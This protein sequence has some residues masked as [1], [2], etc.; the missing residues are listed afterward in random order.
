MRNSFLLPAILCFSVMTTS[1][2][3]AQENE[4]IEFVGRI[5]NN[6]SGTPDIKVVD[7]LAYVATGNT[8]LQIV[9]VS[10]P[11][12][13][14]IVGYNELNGAWRVEIV[15]DNAYVV[16]YQQ[17]SI[18]SISDPEN[19]ELVGS[20]GLTEGG[21]DLVIE[22]DY[23]YL[24]C[25]SSGLQIVDISDPSN[26]EM[27][28]YEGPDGQWARDVVVS[29]D[30]AYLACGA[31]CGDF[32]EGEGGLWIVDV[33]NIENPSDILFIEMMDCFSVALIEGYLFVDNY[34]TLLVFSIDDPEDPQEIGSLVVP[35]SIWGF[36][37]CNEYVF[38]NTF[39]DEVVHIA[40]V[41][42]PTNPELVGSINIP[43][44]ENRISVVNELAFIVSTHIFD[45]D[46]KMRI[47]DLRDIEQPELVNH[48]ERNGYVNDVFVSDEMLYV[49]NGDKGFKTVSIEAPEQPVETGFLDTKSYYKFIAVSEDYTYTLYREDIRNG[50]DSLSIISIEDPEHPQEVRSM[51]WDYPNGRLEFAG[52]Y[53]Y[54]PDYD[55]GIIIIS[56]SD[57]EN[58]ADT[59]HN[60]YTPLVLNL[61][62]SGDYLYAITQ[63]NG[64]YLISLTNPEFPIVIGY[65]DSL[66]TGS[67][68]KS[69]KTNGDFAF[70][71]SR[72]EYL[73]IFD[74]SEPENPEEISNIFIDYAKAIQ[75]SGHYV[76]LAQHSNG[77]SVF[78]IA[79]PEN[80][81]FAGY[82]NT[83]GSTSNLAVYEDGL[84]YAA[85][86]TNLG[87]YRFTDPNFVRSS[88]ISI[89][90]SDY[91]LSAPFPNPFNSTAR[92]SYG[93]PVAGYMSLEVYNLVGQRVYTLVEG[94]KTP[95]AYSSN[96]SAGHL[97]SGMYFVRLKAANLN[98]N[99]KVV[100]VR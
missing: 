52:D 2:L 16:G 24:A 62:V 48:I 34:D 4:N 51:A 83:P 1:T 6:W 63:D 21:E 7:N 99:Q 56:I 68:A 90:P 14:A 94:Y 81:Q 92:I 43:E 65:V 66:L 19:P 46:N 86:G 20:C 39:R 42:D 5:L 11:E 35:N 95:G 53:A 75:V 38:M 85:D 33:S 76:Y 58:P 32:D 29:G 60:L 93:L 28:G 97:P 36:E 88:R 9:D 47:F 59:G 91:Y 25:R 57:P 70:V 27:V 55:H 84:I 12:N 3:Y 45:R 79:D 22:G 50:P 44:W 96:F 23:A 61:A 78:S 73:H 67:T 80:P 77:I 54:V 87:I 72:D 71:I 69:I 18:I 74:I 15:G 98:V 17:F 49:A 89:V 64:L 26:L 13:L 31:W 30:Y 37:L 41:A 100:L 8:G 10:D 82:F 40:S